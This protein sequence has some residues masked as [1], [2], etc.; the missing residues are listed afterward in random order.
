MKKYKMLALD[1]DGTIL[2]NEKVSEVVINA[3]K[4]AVSNG[5]KVVFATG[6]THSHMGHVYKMLDFHEDA[7]HLHISNNG[8]VIASATGKIFSV[9]EPI[10]ED[11]I[12]LVN[13]LEKDNVMFTV[14]T[15]L[16]TYSNFLFKSVDY[17]DETTFTRVKDLTTLEGVTRLAAISD[18]ETIEK[19]VDGLA[20]EWA[21]SY[22]NYYDIW[23]IGVDKGVALTTLANHYNIDMNEVMA[24]GDSDNDLGMFKVAGFS[25][26]MGQGSEMA[27][28]LASDVAPSIHEDGVAWAIRKYILDLK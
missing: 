26:A 8:T 27:K 10:R 16:E 23:P 2:H 22:T 5:V 20:F 25:L 14:A 19:A 7:D 21:N 9:F 12:T 15:A 4:D 1:L 3:I 11:Y 28:T 24:I 18:K 17:S 13:K 6:R